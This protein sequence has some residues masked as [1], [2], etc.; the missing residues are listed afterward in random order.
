M[1]LGV[2]EGWLVEAA[3]RSGLAQQLR[4]ESPGCSGVAGGV[5][6]YSVAAQSC[7][8]PLLLDRGCCLLGH[9]LHHLAKG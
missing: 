1:G 2:A 5:L 8:L 6:G 3:P 9:P 4:S 7:L